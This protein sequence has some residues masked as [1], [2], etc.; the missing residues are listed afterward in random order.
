MTKNFTLPCLL[1][2]A[3]A[4]ACSDDTKK[5]DSGVKDL[6]VI[7]ESGLPDGLGPLYDCDTPGQ[8]CNAHNSCA[9]DPVC[10]ADKKCRP[11]SMQDCSDGLEC[12]KD[13]CKGMG[14]CENVALEGWCALPVKLPSTVDGGVPKTEQ[15]CFKN[16]ERNPT[17]PCMVC[18]ADPADQ[19]GDPSKWS[20]ANGGACDDHNACTK[21]D[22]CQSGVCKGDDFSKQC[23]D[24]YSCTDDLC[25]GKGGCLG[26]QLKSDYCLINGECYKDGQQDATGCNVCDVKTSQSKFTPLGTFCTISGKCY[27]PGDKDPTGC[28]TCDPTKNDKDWTPIAGLC[29]IDGACYKQGAKNSGGCAECDPVT[30]TTAWTVVGDNCLIS[31][32]C[33]KPAAKDPTGCSTCDPTKS[34]TAWTP[35]AGQCLIAAKCYTSGAK[36]PTGCAECDPVLSA[37][38]WSIKGANCLIGAACYQ[39]NATD[40]TGCGLCDPTKSKTAW[41]PVQ[42]KCQIGTS[43]YADQ[44]KDKTGCLMC[45]TAK[46]PTGW[47]P[48]TGATVVS[49]GFED[50]KSPPTGWTLT[51]SDAAVGWVVANKRPGS[52]S[53]SLYYGNPA[54][55]N[56]DSG[57]KNNGTAA[58]PAVA[59]TAGKKAGLSF[60]VWLETES[61]TSYDTL[62]VTVNGTKVWEKDYNTTQKTWQ[63]ITV[64]LSSY[65]GQSVTIKFE[66]DTSDSVSNSTEG[67]YV[68]NITVYHNC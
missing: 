60:L 1:A 12:T 53:Y 2:L 31:N 9:I 35:L 28:G 65:A 63:E 46:N 55:G 64:D 24:K 15:R 38:S 51:N 45:D 18:N 13:V 66:F 67:V 58:M 3:L 59:L 52:G 49:Y 47:T 61:G 34:K 5:V 27:K 48:V 68:D 30:S 4:S 32:V 40:T 42:G 10:G 54:T 16:K 20:L 36:D 22:Y 62:Q 21:D 41:T 6:T 57:A 26:N 25:D 43:C 44:A 19:G 33:Y 29:K 23:A 7:P 39:P 8:A 14:L 11:S 17:D 56:Y 37:S 50:G